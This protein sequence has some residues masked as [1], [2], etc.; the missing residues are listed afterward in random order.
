MNDI[1][2]QELLNIFQESADS[3]HASGIAASSILISDD[4][5]IF[6]G[7]SVLDSMAFVSLISDIEDSVNRHAN[8][9]IFIVLTDIEDLYPNSPYLSAGMLAKYLLDVL[10][11]VG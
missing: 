2:Y 9:D 11:D 5:P 1:T 8:S 6:G 10:K 7:A 4:C 3:L